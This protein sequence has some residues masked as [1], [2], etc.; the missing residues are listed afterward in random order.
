MRTQAGAW[1]KQ[2]VEG[3]ATPHPRL[4]QVLEEAGY[5]LEWQPKDPAQ[6]R[7]HGIDI[8]ELCMTNG[9]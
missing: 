8:F 4:L 3:M 5:Q 2:V 1:G 7:E 6:V 9:A